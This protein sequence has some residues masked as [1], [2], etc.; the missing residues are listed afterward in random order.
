MDVVSIL[1]PTSVTNIVTRIGF[2]HE[3]GND[4]DFRPI[5]SDKGSVAGQLGTLNHYVLDPS[6]DELLSNF[7]TI[8]DF[9]T[10]EEIHANLDENTFKS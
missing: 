7:N 9:S 5:P 2:G 6:I 3:P 1:S 4:L 10:A 8:E